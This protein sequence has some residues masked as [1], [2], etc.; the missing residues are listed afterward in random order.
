QFLGR[1]HRTGIAQQPHRNVEAV[2]NMA[3]AQPR[4]GLRHLTVEAW[5]RTGI[6]DLAAPIAAAVPYSLEVGNPFRIEA[7]FELPPLACH[8]P[9]LRRALLRPPSGP[10]AFEDADIP[11]AHDLEGPPDPRRGEKP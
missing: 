11:G 10:A 2:G 8:L 6:D 3:A 4:A 7:D 5:G 1:A 9:R